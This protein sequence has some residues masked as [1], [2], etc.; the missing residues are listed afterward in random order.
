VEEPAF[1]G[2]R[3]PTGADLPVSGVPT[4]RGCTL[5]GAFTPVNWRAIVGGPVRLALADAPTSLRAGPPGPWIVP[6]ARTDSQLPTRNWG[7]S[8]LSPY[9]PRTKVSLLSPPP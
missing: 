3:F 1:C 6:P 9:F 7:A 8:R 2:S 4:G 5:A